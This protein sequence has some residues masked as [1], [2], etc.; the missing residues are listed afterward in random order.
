MDD[1]EKMVRSQINADEAWRHVAKLSTLERLA[2]TDGEKQAIDYITGKLAEYGIPASRYQFDSFI[3]YPQEAELEILEPQRLTVPCRPRAFAA[4]TPPRGW[5]P[6]WSSSLPGRTTSTRRK[7][8]FA[9][10][11]RADDYEAGPVADKIVLT[12][13]GGPDG[14]KYAE[15]SGAV[16]H[17]HIW[18][19]GEDVI[20]EMIVSSIW[21]TPTPESVQRLVKIPA[22]SVKK[23]DGERLIELCLRGKVRARLK[24]GVFIGWKQVLLPVATIESPEE[25]EKF[26]LVG[27]HHCSWYY[28]ATDNATGDACLLEMAR[29]LYQNRAGLRRSVRIAWWP[30]HSQGRYAGSTW[31]AD[32]FFEDLR[33]NCIGYLGID[34]PGVRGAEIWDCRYN[35]GEVERFMERLMREVTGQEPNIRRPFKAGDQSFW[36]V[37][38]PSFGAYRMLPVDS[39]DRA[40][41]GGSGGGYWWHSPEDTLDKADPKILASDTELYATIVTRLCSVEKLP[42]EFVTVA[43][44]FEKLLSR[45]DG[46]A[47]GQIDLAPALKA[48][49]A[50]EAAAAT[51]EAVTVKVSGTLVRDLN[52]GLMAVSRIIN[53]VLYTVSGDFD[54]DPALQLPMLPGLQPTKRLA[55]LVPADDEYRFLKTRLVRERN[56][57]VDA[58]HRAT[59]EVD[60]LTASLI[61]STE[62]E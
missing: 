8:I 14:V 18:P 59:A 51:L 42:Y 15:A 43:R 55:G 29:A 16:A 40:T 36:G 26:M 31:Y 49:E 48:A 32:N 19:S 38:L 7:M 47:P 52:E 30:S 17:C 62:A 3:S 25:P 35:H 13:G 53:P 56:R 5:R 20:H 46:A 34:S 23:A 2:G 6:R 27:G 11:G 22:I 37:G 45:L 33:R 24:A 12:T 41:V 58:L 50:F 10:T 1:L 21:G 60:R 57:M 28:G 39:P 9:Q 44:D 54:Q 61:R 4:S